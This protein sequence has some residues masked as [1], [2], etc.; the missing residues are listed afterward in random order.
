MPFADAGALAG[1]LLLFAKLMLILMVTTTTGYVVWLLAQKLADITS[2]VVE[3]AEYMA[4][5]IS[6]VMSFTMVAKLAEYVGPMLYT[7]QPLIS[8]AVP[9]LAPMQGAVPVITCIPGGR[10]VTATMSLFMAAITVC[11]RSNTNAA[12]RP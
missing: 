2:W 5:G 9:T 11:F 3:V 1:T 4:S 12:V 8:M 6:W 10:L 7:V